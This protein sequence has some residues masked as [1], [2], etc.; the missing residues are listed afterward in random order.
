V[1]GRFLQPKEAIMKTR[2]NQF[3]GVDRDSLFHILIHAGFVG[4]I[5]I[6]I[7]MLWINYFFIQN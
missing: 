5:L 3:F 4:S 6:G 7:L 2:I 1:G